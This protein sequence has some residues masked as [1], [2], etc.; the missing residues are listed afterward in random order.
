MILDLARRVLLVLAI[1]ATGLSSV[2][3]SAELA[4]D[5]EE[6]MLHRAQL[7]FGGLPADI[8][9]EA[10]EAHHCPFCRLLA[11]P[12]DMR[13]VATATALRPFDG[14]RRLAGLEILP[15]RQAAA[16][17]ARAPPARG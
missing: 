7:A 16:H 10:G 11:D 1:L 12:P 4:P 13:P 15:G 3:S 14:W 9:G 5:R 2:H 6:L 17:P 8:C